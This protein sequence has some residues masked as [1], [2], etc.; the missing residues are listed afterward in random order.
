MLGRRLPIVLT[1]PEESRGPHRPAGCASWIR[2]AFALVL[3]ANVVARARGQDG[4][5]RPDLGGAWTIPLASLRA[6]APPG[7]AFFS[8]RRPGAARDSYRLKLV[9]TEKQALQV[10]LLDAVFDGETLV[11][12]PAPV[13]VTSASRTPGS[14][15]QR[16]PPQATYAFA[17]DGVFEEL[18]R[19]GDSPAGAPPA[20]RRLVEPPVRCPAEWEPAEEVLWA[21]QDCGFGLEPIYR[22]A[23]QATEANGESVR[24]RF[25]V[26]R[27]DREQLEA[28]LEPLHVSPEH[29]AFTEFEF[30]NVW[31]RDSGPIVLKRK[32]DGARIVADLGDN[33]VGELTGARDDAIPRQYAHLRRWDHENL[34]AFALPGGNFMTDGQGRVFL[35]NAVLE[36]EH[37][38]SEEDVETYLN[39]LGAREVVY[40]ERMPL[41]AARLRKSDPVDPGHI[42][43]FAKLVDPAT[44]L[45]SD[46]DDDPGDK[47]VLDRNAKRFEALGYRVVRL[48]A[49]SSLKLET[50]TNALLVGHTA[51]VPI[52][53]VKA[54]DEAA[55]EAYRRLGWKAVGIDARAIVQHNGAVHCLS[56]QVPR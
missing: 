6:T 30:D 51:L 23:V 47:A 56:M 19:V 42:D 24:H 52:Y 33:G 54:R 4:G 40:F 38:D 46:S 48:L 28:E 14:R 10:S 45:V 2:V 22:A 1:A 20:M 44:V 27:A 50:Y 8:E 35:T 9:F 15:S 21:Y 41:H 43:M 37:N 25:F 34:N 7:L 55:L 13:A 3:L 32:K 53:Q 31:M 36:N 12:R 29:L 11:L 18:A 26:R 39:Q 5:P 16:P 17:P 49:A